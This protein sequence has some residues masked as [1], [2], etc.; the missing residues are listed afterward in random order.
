MIIPERILNKASE[1]AGAWRKVRRLA[2][3]LSLLLVTTPLLGG[4]QFAVM[5]PKGPIGAQEKSII[6]LSTGLMLIVVVPVI[7]LTL[8]FAWRYRASNSKATFAPDW[9]HSNRI[10]AVVWL[11]PCLIVAILGSVTWVSSHTLDPYRPIAAAAKPID[12][13]VVSLDWKWLFIYPDL[14]IASVNELAFPVGTPVR[15]RMTSSSVM[16]AFFIPRLGSQIYTMPGMETKL[17]LLADNPGTYEGISA[18]YSG[19]GFSD[20][21]FAARAMS[22]ADFAK[23][24]ETVRR[25]PRELTMAAYR[26]LAKPSEDVPVGYY[27]DIAS[28]LYHDVLNKCADG[29]SCT[30]DNVRLALAKESFGAVGLCKT[31]ESRI[32]R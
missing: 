30:D 3:S 4:C 25:S 21:K 9:S 12:V 29:S 7:A 27:G 17:S 20:M 24:V 2:S 18:N 28:N 19:D 16:D 32:L 31:S 8:A 1:T 15:F 11:V 5:D 22:A 14:K 23:W 6:L 13:D 26:Q 10:E